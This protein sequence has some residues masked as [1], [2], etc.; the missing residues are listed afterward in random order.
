ME[1]LGENNVKKPEGSTPDSRG[2]EPPANTD[3]L[4]LTPSSTVELRSLVNELDAECHEALTQVRQLTIEKSELARAL[5][6]ERTQRTKLELHIARSLVPQPVSFLTRLRAK[7]WESKPGSLLRQGAQVFVQALHRAVPQCKQVAY[8]LLPLQYKPCLIVRSRSQE[9]RQ[10]VRSMLPFNTW[11]AR[12]L[13]LSRKRFV[14]VGTFSP[15]S[16]VVAEV[17]LFVETLQASETHRVEVQLT[18]LGEVLETVWADIPAKQESRPIVFRCMLL[19]DVQGKEIVLQAR[20]LSLEKDELITLTGFGLLPFKRDPWVVFDE[21]DC[22]SLE[23]QGSYLMPCFMAEADLR[24]SVIHVSWLPA[25]EYCQYIPLYG[26]RN[27][28]FRFHC[29]EQP[30]TSLKVIWGT[31][32]RRNNVVIEYS[33]ETAETHYSGSFSAIDLLD[34]APYELPISPRVFSAMAGQ[35]V[36][37][38]LSAPRA[39]ADNQVAILVA[40]LS[41]SPYVT[42]HEQGQPLFPMQ[43]SSRRL[44]EIEGTP[45]MRAVFSGFSQQQER[46][47]LSILFSGARAPWWVRRLAKR[48]E[49]V[50]HSAAIFLSPEEALQ[51]EVAVRSDI[52]LV[53]DQP[54]T[55]S[56]REL[57][58]EV[59]GS[60]GIVVGCQTSIGD[61]SD[62]RIMP[63]APRGKSELFEACSSII[64]V[65]KTGDAISRGGATSERRA[66]ALSHTAVNEWLHTEIERHKQTHMPR[67]TIVTV[68]YRKEREIPFFLQA[69]AAQDYPGEVELIVVDDCSPDR[70]RE[71]LYRFYTELESQGAELPELVMF[72]NDTN[73]GNCASRNRAIEAATGDVVVVV[74]C[75]CL[76]NESFLSAHVYSHL[77]H[78]AD[79]VIGPCNIESGERSPLAVLAEFDYDRDRI[80]QEARLQDPLTLD[81]FVNCITRNFSIKRQH[82]TEELFDTAFAYSASPDSGF[83]WEDV[84]MGYRLYQRGLRIHFT[85]DAF[86]VHV[87]HPSTTVAEEQPLKSLKNFK[88]LL[89]K[90]PAIRHQ[91]RRWSMET[92]E[93]IEKWVA[94]S[95]NTSNADQEGIR[96]TVGNMYPYPF[97]IRR[98]KR[99]RVL[100]YRWHVPHQYELYKLPHTFALISDLPTGFTHDWEPELRP[101][102]SNSNFIPLEKVRSE[103]YDLAI[104]HFDENVLAPENCNS[105]ISSDWGGNFLWMLQ[106]VPNLPK[107]AVCHGT[108]QFI[109]Q[110]QPNYAASDLGA[111]IEESRSTLVEALGDI[112]VVCNSYQAQREWGFKNSR[113]IWHG[114]DPTEFSP[115]DYTGGVMSLSRSVRE[116]PHYRG[117]SLYKA[118]TERLPESVRPAYHVPKKPPLFLPQHPT[119]AHLKYRI[120][121]ETLRR[122]S[123]YFNPTIRSPMPRS[124]GE[125]MMAGL[126]TVSAANH[127]VQLF[128]KNGWNG[129]YSDSPQELADYI[130]FLARNES[131]RRTIGQRGRATAQDLFNHDRYLAAWQALLSEVVGTT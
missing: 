42:H 91:A 38:R 83:G 100:S 19:R 92:L 57:V 22:T 58:T 59:K 1:M 74:D 55:K 130:L 5:K 96:H 27:V 75:D 72:V 80:L 26:D 23:E 94:E 76:L 28:S 45:I 35:L 123:V 29:P 33:V 79:V 125:A 104:L 24:D 117:Y 20:C 89:D 111:V 9:G 99:L 122:Y 4:P 53:F 37:V 124:R 108:P 90:H 18:H 30:L 127:D 102:P 39:R 103:D 49:E 51:A 8:R 60:Y 116:R 21:V 54:Y 126:V 6:E 128:I 63:L 61:E 86:S 3:T 115:T 15:S 106:N 119:Y 121:R 7:A 88:R 13:P 110:Y 82:I 40:Q 114:F 77:F 65:R 10:H 129:F 66:L 120:Y 107:V 98:E 71:T 32:Y 118:V 73:Q 50:G 14:Y 17:V 105:I 87:S 41:K 112:P 93:K 25:H 47:H 44:S 48:L 101:Q 131:A 43:R 97:A 34:N 95:G 16:E 36:T 113:V 11:P 67:I 62:G 31:S 64:E 81:S 78:T 84:E 52:V 68:L 70:S 2:S 56:L 109:G 46:L 12:T 85:H 69:L